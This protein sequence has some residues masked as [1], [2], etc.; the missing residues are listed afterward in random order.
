MNKPKLEDLFFL[1][2]PSGSGKA[3]IDMMFKLFSLAAGQQKILYPIT[4]RGKAISPGRTTLFSELKHFLDEMGYK[5]KGKA[6]VL[7][8]DDDLLLD[9]RVTPT[10]MISMLKEA[11]KRNINLIASYKVEHPTG[12]K[13]VLMKPMKGGGHDFYTDEELKQLKRFD[14]LPQ[15]TACGMGFYYGWIDLDYQF[16][17]DERAED[18]NFFLDHGMTLHYADLPLLHEKKVLV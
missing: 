2:V 4:C 1:L 12:W 13:N 17:Y 3:D 10:E 5:H 8:W 7:L 9:P 16:H 18:V 14:E 6:R 11:D 15:G